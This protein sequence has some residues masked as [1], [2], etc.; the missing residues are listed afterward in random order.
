M[1]L[2]IVSLKTGKKYKLYSLLI[3]FKKEIYNF[4][5]PTER[6][7]VKLGRVAMKYKSIM[8]EILIS[9]KY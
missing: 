6:L 5:S 9:Q 1:K 4:L 7:R 8:T 2:I 3:E